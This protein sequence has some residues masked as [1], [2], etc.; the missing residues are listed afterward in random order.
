MILMMEDRGDADERVISWSN[1]GFALTSPGF[2]SFLVKIATWFGS[3]L[4]RHCEV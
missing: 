4:F 2:G 1:P 3:T